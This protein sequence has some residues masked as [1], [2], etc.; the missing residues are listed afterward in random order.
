MTAF[1]WHP[2]EH[3]AALDGMLMLTLE[4]RGAYNTLLDLI[5]DRSGPIPDDARWLSGWMGCSLR[6]WAALRAS[7]IEKGKIV[8][9]IL[10]GEPSLMNP[11]AA[12]EIE[13]QAKLQRN[14]SET[15]SKGG[16][17]RAENSAKSNENNAPAQAEVK[18][19]TETKTETEEEPITPDG[20]IVPLKAPKPNGFARFWEAY[21]EKIG[22]PKAEKAYAKAIRAIPGP[23]PPGLILAGV[24]RAKLSR[25]WREGYIP[26]PTTW[27]NRG[28]WDDE[29]S[30]IQPLRQPHG[31]S[32][33]L[34]PDA[35]R[36]A[37][38]ANYARAFAAS[39]VVARNR[40][41]R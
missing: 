9:L 1:G 12:I 21:P 32:D 30:N 15:G 11:R 6:R 20:V 24:E 17:K 3:R 25:Q 2:R 8:A 36:S 16:R 13:N 39:E 7:L 10:T 40:S 31:R 14:R 18:L 28:G 37:R 26:H 33:P 27:L 23:D 35:K 4:E 34:Q 41:E 38:E 19:L 29:P 22:K 5:Y